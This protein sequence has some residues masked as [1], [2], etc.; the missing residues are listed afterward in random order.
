MFERRTA[1]I[2]EAGPLS[3][4]PEEVQPRQA[5]QEYG[6]KYMAQYCD[7]IIS[8]TLPADLTSAARQEE[9]GF[10]NAWKVC[11]VA[12]IAKW[13]ARTGKALLKGKWVDVN[14]GDWARFVIRCRWVAKEFATYKS[15]PFLA[16]TPRPSA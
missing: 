7:D 12:P 6:D 15:A 2:A 11:G 14:K 4:Q 1:E 10:M 5:E 13:W 8:E 16:A 9:L 3:V